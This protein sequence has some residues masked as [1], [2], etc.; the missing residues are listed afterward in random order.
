MNPAVKSWRSEK[1]NTRK[2]GTI[3]LEIAGTCVFSG[4]FVLLREAD[5]LLYSDYSSRVQ[6]NESIYGSVRSARA[7]PVG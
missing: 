1:I 6:R 7:R 4:L 5:P 3:A 2:Q